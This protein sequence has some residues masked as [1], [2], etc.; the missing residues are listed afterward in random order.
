MLQAP[1]HGQECE[2]DGDDKPNN[3]A[4]RHRKL[5]LAI[6][7]CGRSGLAGWTRQ[8]RAETSHDATKAAI[9]RISL[10]PASNGA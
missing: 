6:F 9:R 10:G 3:G 7:E 4:A 2:K 8:R 1:I 5:A